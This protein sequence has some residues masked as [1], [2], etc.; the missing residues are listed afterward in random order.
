[1]FVGFSQTKR[2]TAAAAAVG[3]RAGAASFVHAAAD[4][5]SDPDLIRILASHD[6]GVLA[7]VSEAMRADSEFAPVWDR[8]VR[9]RIIRFA[10]GKY[11]GSTRQKTKSL[12]RC[13]L[14]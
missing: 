10:L 5:K 7:L 4:L 11:C 12:L 9:S 2:A 13:L 8:L 1:M 3:K 14:K 6:E